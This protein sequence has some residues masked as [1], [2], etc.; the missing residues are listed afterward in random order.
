MYILEPIN[1]PLHKSTLLNLKYS[2]YFLVPSCKSWN[3]EKTEILNTLFFFLLRYFHFLKVF[4]ESI[5]RI[6][7]IL[8]TF[9]ESMLCSLHP[10]YLMRTLLEVG[11]IVLCNEWM[12]KV[13]WK[14]LSINNLYYIEWEWLLNWKNSSLYP[15]LWKI[16]LSSNSSLINR[17]GY[18]TC[19]L[20]STYKFNL[21]MV[22]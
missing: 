3:F 4:Y 2:S 5:F 8:D 7:L 18:L 20:I 6:S 13:H 17:N 14:K 22:A 15:E 10:V 16:K 21:R 9:F 11:I 19:L 12:Y 1:I